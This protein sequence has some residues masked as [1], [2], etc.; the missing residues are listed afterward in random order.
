MSQSNCLGVFS[1]DFWDK[2]SQ[3]FMILILAVKCVFRCF[4][5]VTVPNNLLYLLRILLAKMKIL[6]RI[7]LEL[8]KKGAKVTLTDINGLL[9][10]YLVVHTY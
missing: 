7:V 1:G 2:K 10:F 3:T 8:L 9:Q 4:Y 5:I 6:Y